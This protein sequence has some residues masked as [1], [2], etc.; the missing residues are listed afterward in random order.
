MLKH[1]DLIRLSGPLKPSA[2][3]LLIWYAIV[4]YSVTIEL[5]YTFLLSVAHY[6]TNNFL[7][8]EFFYSSFYCHKELFYI[9]K[10][11]IK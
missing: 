10:S 8:Q 1:K 11:P 5:K 9:I 3:F 7:C 4:F 2:G 6:N